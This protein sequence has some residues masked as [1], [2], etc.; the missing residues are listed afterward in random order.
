MI[1]QIQRRLQAALAGVTALALLPVA[2]S[3]ASYAGTWSVS[4]T[5]SSAHAS[6][7]CK[8]AQ[9]GN[10][11][12]GTCKGPDGAGSA[13][14]VVSGREVSFTWHVVRTNAIG[15]TGAASFR[16]VLG[17]DGVIRGTWT[18]TAAPGQSGTFTAIRA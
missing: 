9:S 14:G 11:L 15:A 4:A 17:N 1:L 5:M 7:V 13:S 10:A 6:P 2:A 3:A 18:F 8:F 16:G 12:S